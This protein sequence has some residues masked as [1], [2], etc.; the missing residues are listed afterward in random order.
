VAQRILS[1]I[2]SLLVVSCL[3][4]GSGLAQAP[5]CAKP[6]SPRKP[7]LKVGAYIYPPAAYIDDDGALVGETV[8]ALRAV[9]SGMGYKPQFVVMPFKRCLS[10]MRDGLFPI[11]L[12]CVIND[13]RLQYMMY[14]APVYH[15][16]SVL[17]KRGSDL[18]GCWEKFEDLRGKHIGATS[19]YAYGPEWDDAKGQQYFKVDTVSGEHPEF[20]HFSK[21]VEG[22]NTMFICEKKLGLFLKE[23]YAPRFNDIFPARKALARSGHF[24]RPSRYGTLRKTA[25][26]P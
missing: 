2:L 5:S 18:S 20:S 16:D 19:G 17:W 25:L 24:A 9:L 8:E 4:G 11:M 13:D 15:I 3:L 7:V 6:S 12:P 10:F 1:A 22:R 21:L 26:I 14:S 23:R